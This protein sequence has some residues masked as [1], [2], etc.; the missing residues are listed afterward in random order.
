MNCLLLIL[1]KAH[2][3]GKLKNDL[4]GTYLSNCPNKHGGFYLNNSAV[5]LIVLIGNATRPTNKDMM[6]FIRK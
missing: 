1:K 5:F 3:T 4:M 2:G 6:A